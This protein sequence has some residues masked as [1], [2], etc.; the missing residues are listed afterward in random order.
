M[1][2]GVAATTPPTTSLAM[3]EYPH[4][5]GTASSLLGLARYAFGA[6]TAPLVGLG[7]AD[8]A[9][10]LGLVTLASVVL[11]AI[12]YPAF[13]RRGY[14]A[15]PPVTTTPVPY[16]GAELITGP[17]DGPPRATECCCAR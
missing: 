4:L 6:L 15:N 17:V 16:S 2:S 13:I 9:L 7:G 12:T 1:V 8:T 3:A 10:P 14:T 5:A 11:A